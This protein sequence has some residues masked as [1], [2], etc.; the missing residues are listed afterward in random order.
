MF[1]NRRGEAGFTITELAMVGT[2]IGILAT[3]AAPTWMRVRQ[4]ALAMLCRQ[5]QKKIYEAASMYEFATGQLLDT[6]ANNGSAIRNRL[7][8]SGYIT[9]KITFECPASQVAD[10]DDI[11]LQYVGGNLQGTRC[12]VLPEPHAPD[13]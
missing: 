2:M 8:D 7:M 3:M 1:R 6:I 12:T 5:N 13:F 11:R 9:R 10:Y 4:D